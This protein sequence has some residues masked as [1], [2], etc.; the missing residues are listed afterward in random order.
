MLADFFTYP[1]FGGWVQVWQLLCL[2]VLVGL[3][4]FL[5]QYRKRQ[6]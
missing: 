2:V 6:M 5:I 4:I 3:I 1:L